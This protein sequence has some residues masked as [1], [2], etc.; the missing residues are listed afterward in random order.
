M[1]NDTMPRI[2]HAVQTGFGRPSQWNA[3][4]DKGQYLYLRYRS[5]VG[6]VTAYSSADPE[7][8]DGNVKPLIEWADGTDSGD[9]SLADFA[10]RS[11]LTLEIPY[12]ED[13]DPPVQ[14]WHYEPGSP[15]DWNICRQPE[16]LAAGDLGDDPT[17]PL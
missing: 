2:T 8:W 6:S 17:A 1:T 16:R 5:G 3:W 9:I 15:C 12:D 11:G 13:D 14:C 10:Q 7:E 4:T